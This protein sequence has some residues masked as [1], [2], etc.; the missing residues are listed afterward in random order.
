MTAYITTT[1]LGSYIRQF[2]PSRRHLHKLGLQP[3][4][5]DA[6][7]LGAELEGA[8]GTLELQVL[9]QGHR[10]A[11]GAQVASPSRPNGPLNTQPVG[12]ARASG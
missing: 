12:T 11:I 1:R 10:A 6:A 3:D 8:G 9:D 2:A 5:A 4:R 7:D